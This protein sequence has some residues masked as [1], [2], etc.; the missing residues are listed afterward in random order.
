MLCPPSP[1]LTLLGSDPPPICF[2]C[3]PTSISDN[4]P[5]LKELRVWQSERKE[6]GPWK[7]GMISCLH[8]LVIPRQTSFM[9]LHTAMIWWDGWLSEIASKSGVVFVQTELGPWAG[10]NHRFWTIQSFEDKGS[11]SS[12]LAQEELR[13]PPS[14]R[15]PAVP[16]SAASQRHPVAHLWHGWSL[17]PQSNY[18]LDF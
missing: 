1:C 9:V 4:S 7:H 17:S 13:P 10:L 12:L 16:P 14:T 6:N 15:M 18:Y 3:T 5:L 8:L 11:K 2:R